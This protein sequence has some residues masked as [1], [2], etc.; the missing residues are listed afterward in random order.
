MY[1]HGVTSQTYLVKKGQIQELFKKKRVGKK[2]TNTRLLACYTVSLGR[3][4]GRLQG[5]RDR[6][7]V[8]LCVLWTF[9]PQMYYLLKTSKEAK[10]KGTF[11]NT[12]TRPRTA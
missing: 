11:E 1:S 6:K 2:N 9:K 3:Y 8:T 7:E 4:S 5:T 12:D 10:L